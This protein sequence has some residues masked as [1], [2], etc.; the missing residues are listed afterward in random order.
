MH[1]LIEIFNYFCNIHFHNR[2]HV[3]AIIFWLLEVIKIVLTTTMNIGCKFG[4]NIYEEIIELIWYIIRI[5]KNFTVIFLKLILCRLFFPSTLFIVFHV[6]FIL[7]LLITNFKRKSFSF[8][9]YEL[10]CVIYFCTF[11]ISEVL[12]R[13]ESEY[14]CCYY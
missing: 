13:L 2:F 1:L 10:T 6:C 3:H 11:W 14:I 5:N 4:A 9:L 8:L 7:F 12:F